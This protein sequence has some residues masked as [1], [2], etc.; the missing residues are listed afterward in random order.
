MISSPC[1]VIGQTLGTLFTCSEVNN[2]IRIR[3]PFLYPDGD[4]IDLFYTELDG[5]PNVTDFGETLRW[6]RMQSLSPKRSPKQQKLIEDVCLNHGI[7]LYKGM[8]MSRV[9]KGE[10]LAK[11]VIRVSQGAMRTAD[12][13]F[14][15]RTRAI[16][17]ASE[18]VEL[19]FAEKGIKFERYQSFAGKS[20]RTWR[21]DFL[22]RM[23]QK[24]SLLYILSTGSRAA[25]RSLVEHVV[26]A[27]YDLSSLKVDPHILNFISLFDDTMDIWNPEDFNLVQDLSTITC[28]SK[29]DELLEVLAA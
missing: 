22:T 7:E 18:E 21:V 16:E 6:L 5:E 13:W 17:S 9:K 12:L 15:L 4:V 29:P 26:A 24:E 2:Y 20:G 14:T 25:A 3:T 23:P 8:L 27:W 11:T 28:W 19:F 1:D 10:S